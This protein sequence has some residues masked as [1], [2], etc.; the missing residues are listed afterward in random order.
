ME[1]VQQQTQSFNAYY[2]H[3]VE[4]LLRYALIEQDE[5]R[6]WC[7]KDSGETVRRRSKN[8][9]DV[10]ILVEE[11][12]D[13]S[14]LQAKLQLCNNTDAIGLFQ[15]HS[16]WQTQARTTVTSITLSARILADTMQEIFESGTQDESMYKITKKQRKAKYLF[17]PMKWF[18]IFELK[19]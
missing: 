1:K 4:E 5:G 18:L 13:L 15:V 12:F 14:R 10:N 19:N 2:E 3:L 8:T 17:R 7:E 9:D 16:C 6:V 11:K